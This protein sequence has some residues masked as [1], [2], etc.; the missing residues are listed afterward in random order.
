MGAVEE[1]RASQGFFGSSSAAG[2]MRQIKTAVDKKVYSP[3]RR[4]SSPASALPSSLLSEH[5]GR[6]ATSPSYVL[7][8][9][10]TADSLMNVYWDYVF[11][12]YPLVDSSYMKTEYMKVWQGDPLHYD[13]NMVMCTFNVIFALA[14]Q[15]ADFIAPEERAASADAYFSRAKGLFQFNLWDTGSAGL[16]QC[17]LL[18]AQYLQSTDSAHQCWIV[19]GLAIRNAQS[20]GLHLPQ[21]I[22]QFHNFG[23]QQLARKIWHGC[24]L[25]DRVIAMTFGR[26]AMISKSSNNTVPLPIIVDD[27]FIS[28]ETTSESCQPAGQPSMMAFYAKTLELYE[29]MNDVLLSVY[30]SPPDEFPDDIHD[31]YFSNTISEGERTIFELDRSLT[32]WTCSLPA[33]LSGDSK[34]VTDNPILYRQQIVLQARYTQSSLLYFG[35]DADVSPFVNDRFLHVRMLLFRPT[36]SKYCVARDNLLA[37]SMISMTESFPNRVALQC[38]IICVRV[39]QESINLIHNNVPADGTGGPLPA[40]WYNILCKIFSICLNHWSNITMYY[41]LDIYT[42]A[43]VLIAGRLCPTILAEITGDS[44]THSWHC[45]LEILRNYQNY[46]SSARRCIAALEILYEQ[47]VSEAHPAP[48]QAPS[49]DVSLNGTAILNDMSF[50]E[51][52]NATM[53]EGF[54]FPDFQDMSWLNSV[55]SNLF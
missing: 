44:I 9:R 7:P 21:T 22:A 28:A 46:S 2:F 30:K 19:T 47:V 53:M 49:H 39:A 37:H 54:E 31:F 5:S 50:G 10:R 51:G 23:E 38:S 15:L 20:L 36:L 41:F 48:N 27:E 12:L 25:M 42:A 35:V 18:M 17:L 29:I 16:I 52:I 13:E 11:P 3:E 32:R 43:T 14:S 33:H 1:G 8:P 55:P 24:V 45:A 4:L 40:W 34:I 6:T 26:P